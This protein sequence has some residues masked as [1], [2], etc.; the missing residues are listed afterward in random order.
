ME[1]KVA[2]R[3]VEMLDERNVA[4]C[5]RALSTPSLCPSAW[6]MRPHLF[7][8][9]SFPQV[10]K[11]LASS[12][13][14][15][16][17]V[18]FLDC[19][20]ELARHV[21]AAVLESR[22]ITGLWLR[23]DSI[24]SGAC[25]IVA[26]GLS[27]NKNNS[28]SILEAKMHKLDCESA[29]SLAN[30]LARNRTLLKVSLNFI[31]VNLYDGSLDILSAGLRKNPVIKEFLV[32]HTR[33]HGYCLKLTES[34]QETI[35]RNQ[36]NWNYAVKFVLCAKHNKRQVEAFDLLCGAPCFVSSVAKVTGKPRREVQQ[37]VNSAR[38]FVHTNYLLITKVVAEKVECLPGKGT[39]LD[40]LYLDC[41]LAIAQYLKV[42]DVLYN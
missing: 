2:D 22:F 17:L 25:L 41:W 8:P 1:G 30:I 20:R 42:S 11:A 18:T 28:L 24:S 40:G 33:R 35:D 34:M 27:Q 15:H 5:L 19:D 4:A 16:L 13:V 10:C 32:F 3:A 29:K 37:M 31:R 26:E 9:S 39:Q 14:K 21:C 38:R 23:E 7:P 36:K 12:K 6:E